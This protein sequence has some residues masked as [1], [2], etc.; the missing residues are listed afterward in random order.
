MQ[1]FLISIIVVMVSQDSRPINFSERL[2]PFA[3]YL[4]YS[5]IT[6]AQAKSC[7]CLLAFQTHSANRGIKAYTCNLQCLHISTL[8]FQEEFGYKEKQLVVIC[9]MDENRMTRKGSIT[10]Q[11]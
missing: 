11:V 9:P 8:L 4:T 6:K 10:E 2:E 3:G 7:P 1:S 5:A